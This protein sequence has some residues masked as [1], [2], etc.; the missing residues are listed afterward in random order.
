MRS[1]KIFDDGFKSCCFTGYRPQKFPF[2]LEK[3]DIKYTEFENRLC[4][5][6]L[7][8]CER[9]VFTFYTGMAMGF[10]IIAAETV[11]QIRESYNK[12]AI[13]I[14][15]AIPFGGQA[16]KFDD[17]WKKRYDAVLK[18]V[19]ETVVLSDNYYRGCFWRRNEFMVDNSD[20]VVTWF[21]GKKG[22]TASTLCYAQKNE[23]EIINL[24][25]GADLNGEY[26]Y[27]DVDTD[28]DE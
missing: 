22:G 14:V 8:L 10:D 15:A 18:S 4:D 20:V 19:D 5:T 21:D 23:K 27:F 6:V 7:S 12:G 3:D 16:S 24:Y 17:A 25:N 26:I 11:L 1:I 13:Q 28:F 2:A 9:G